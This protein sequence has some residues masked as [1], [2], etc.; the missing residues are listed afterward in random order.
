MPYSNRI[1]SNVALAIAIAAAGALNTGWLLCVYLA[2][3]YRGLGQVT[4]ARECLQD[5][6]ARIELQHMPAQFTG[7]LAD[8]AGQEAKER[9]QGVLEHVDLPG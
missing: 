3:G 2:Q 4:Q 6:L 8:A 7:P 9:E 1:R 5:M